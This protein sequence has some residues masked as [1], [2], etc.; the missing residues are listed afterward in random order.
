[1]HQAFLIT[2]SALLLFSFIWGYLWLEVL[3]DPKSELQSFYLQY[4]SVHT[5]VATLNKLWL[6]TLFLGVS[7]IAASLFIPESYPI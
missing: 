6:P 5:A 4:P 1:M 7:L 3:R 2:G